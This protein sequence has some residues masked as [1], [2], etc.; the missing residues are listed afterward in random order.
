MKRYKDLCIESVLSTGDKSLSFLYPA[1]LGE[2]IKV[3]GYIATKTDEFVIKELQDLGE[4]KSIKAMLNL[5]DLEGKTF[6]KFETVE[7]TISESIRLALAGTGWT[8]GECN[9]TK[10]RTIR[11]THSSSLAIIQ[12]AKKVYRVEYKFDT[13]NKTINIYDQIGSDKGVYLKD[14]LN[15]VSLD[16]QSNS[17]DFYTRIKA[18]GKTI[19][20]ESDE[21]VQLKVIAENFQYSRKIKE[22]I[23]NDER[24]TDIH[25]LRE[26][27]EAKL[28]ELSKPYVAYAAD[29]IDLSKMNI[30]YKDILNYELGDTI[31]LVS[32]D[33]GIRE[34]QRIVKINEYPDEPTRNKCEI[35][36]TTLNFEDIQKEF[37]DT[38]SIVDNITSDD[39]T[40]SE[41][42]IKNTVKKL[43]VD[44][45]NVNEL[46]AVKATIGEL[47]VNKLGVD[48]ADI[49]FAE[50]D[51]AIINK[52]EIIDLEAATGKID[53]L[54]TK[55][56]NIETLV[57]GNLTSDNIHSFNITADK[58]TMQDGFI[59]NAMIDDLSASKIKS[60]SI[61]TNEVTIASKDGSIQIADN[62]QQFKDKNNK[63]R[64]QMGQ[65]ANGNFNFILLD[66]TGSGTIIDHTGI[67]EKAIADGLIKENMIGNGEI[68]GKK[69]NISSMLTEVN[70]DEN[71]STIKASKIKLDTANQ[72][73]EVGF[74]SM[75]T[76]INSIEVGAVNLLKDSKERILPPLNKGQDQDNYN[77]AR[78]HFKAK[79][80]QTYTISAKVEVTAGVTEMI[81][82]YP[83]PK[84]KQMAVKIEGGRIIYTFKN[85]TPEVDSILLYSGVAGSTRGIG[86][87]FRDIKIEK[88]NKATDYSPSPDNI[89]DQIDTV[90][91]K[92][93]SH[94]TSLGVQA[95]KIET[96]IKDTTIEKSG[97]TV[98]L[99]DEYSKLEQ[100][101]GGLGSTVGSHSSSI[102]TIGEKSDNALIT[103]N[104]AKTDISNL[105]GKVTSVETKQTQ[106]QQ[107]LDGITQRVSSNE[108][109]VTEVSGTVTNVKDKV[110][111]MKVGGRNLLKNSTFNTR[112]SSY[113]NGYT[114]TLN[115]IIDGMNGNRALKVTLTSQ[116]TANTLSQTVYLESNTEY[117]VSVWI[118][119]DDV[120]NTASNFLL[121][122]YGVQHR[123]DGTVCK[124]GGLLSVGIQG[125]K[126]TTPW[127][128][129]TG[130]LRT[131]ADTTRITFYSYNRSYTGSAYYSEIMFQKGNIVSD[132][133]QAPE[134]IT[135]SINKI[136]SELTDFE[137]TVTGSFKDGVI[138]EAEA[139]AIAQNIQ[140]LDM[141]KADIDSE[142]TALRA[143]TLL[144]GTPATNIANAKVDFNSAHDSLKSFI[145]SAIADGK[146]TSS[147]VASVNSAFETYRSKLGVYK[148][149]VQE[150]L[151]FISTT[152]TNNVIIGGRNLIIPSKLET[153]TPY[154][155]II[156]GSDGTITLTKV[157]ATYIALK[158]KGLMPENKEYTISGIA[159]LDGASITKDFFKN[160]KANTYNSGTSSITVNNNGYFSIS[161]KWVGNSDWLFHCF[162]GG[163]VGSKIV[164][165]NLK[166]EVGNKPTDWT[167]SV[168][169]VEKSI[170]DVD[171][172]VT[173]TSNKV[174]EL[175]TNVDS[176]TGRVSATESNVTT[177]TTT[178]NNALSTA[179][180][181]NTNATN[182]NNKADNLA[183]DKVNSFNNFSSTK[184]MKG[185][186]GYRNTD[187]LVDNDVYG[188]VLKCVSTADTQIISPEFIVDPT[189]AYKLGLSILKNF[190]NPTSGSGNRTRIYFGL[191][192]Y[193]QNGVNVGVKVGS[194]ETYNTNVYFYNSSDVMT[195]WRD[196]EA[197]LLPHDTDKTK[198]PVGKNVQTS[199]VRMHPKT[200]RVHIRFLNYYNDGYSSTMYFAHPF[201][202]EVD[203]TSIVELSATKTQ[204]SEAKTEIGK[205]TDRVSTTESNITTINGKV[206]GQETRLNSAETK[207]TDSNFQVQVNSNLNRV[208]K[209]RYIRDY[210]NGSSANGGNHWC[211]LQAIDNKGV[212]VAKNKIVTG[213]GIANASKFTDGII[214]N[215][216]TTAN[217]YIQVDLGAIY[218]NIDLLKVWHYWADGR[219]YNATKTEIS[220][221]GINWIVVFDSSK[222]GTYKETKEGH[223]IRLNSNSINTSIGKFDESGWEISHTDVGTK[224]VASAKGFN[225]LD[226][227]GESIGSLAEDSGLTI[228]TANKVYA[229]NIVSIYE[230]ASA[231]YVNSSY[232]G[233]SDGTSAKPFKN[234]ADCLNSF[235]VG[236]KTHLAYPVT[237]HVISNGLP[238][239]SITIK[240][241][242][243]NLLQINFPVNFKWVGI[244]DI[245]TNACFMIDN[246]TSRIFIWGN[247]SDWNSKNGALLQCNRQRVFRVK[248]S[249]AVV[250][251][252]CNLFSPPS[253]VIEI[254]E[255]STVQLEQVDFGRSWHDVACHENSKVYMTH[256]CGNSEIMCSI[257]SGSTLT[258]GRNNSTDVRPI[259]QVLDHSGQFVNKG[260][261]GGG[262]QGSHFD[263][264]PIPPTTTVTGSWDLTSWSHSGSYWQDTRDIYQ[265]NYG[266]GNHIGYMLPPSSCKSTIA[267]ATIN[268]ASLFIRR[269]NGGG[270]SGAVP[271]YLWGSNQNSLGSGSSAGASR[272]YGHIGSLAWGQSGTFTIPVQ[273]INDYK[274]GIIN[275]LCL[276][277]SDG[278]NYFRSDGQ[279]AKINITYTK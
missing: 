216:Y 270:S 153:Y 244:E 197:Y 218:E 202:Q 275:S 67:K 226:S 189:K 201:V 249:S 54:E 101:V 1:R 110:D 257:E 258:I 82:V 264:L 107:S 97:N 4:Y 94:E 260:T 120:V 50:I 114:S 222:T 162:V 136:S 198:L 116:Y 254:Y 64:L 168:E 61:D 207:L 141:E 99:K 43:T 14:S 25:A 119:T 147:E 84:G 126:G 143:N 219:T 193:D 111:N 26:D 268:S 227:K 93:T 62:T 21:E 72:T 23:W 139:K 277:T 272:N 138:Q 223:I 105:S 81:T 129:Y 235:Y 88:G 155:T 167:P 35:A 33:K 5:E 117:V 102:T 68:G 271:M 79:L 39:G 12:E 92:T 250:I 29:I 76:E 179:N 121:S 246:C 18:F 214:D 199:A 259:G 152:K 225:I 31:T 85:T 74:N 228:L 181:A 65:D 77:Y 229:N 89:Q 24:Y 40:I 58:V 172:K 104:S 265:G 49:K 251:H 185:W 73:L 69:I 95:G 187:I 133:S 123:Q 46:N 262:S 203:T 91:E 166:F 220:S 90:V 38:S 164:I 158:M 22:L 28:N 51:S 177:V 159:T 224:T 242:S 183:F 212:N 48:Q 44:K 154:T 248:N 15:L 80:D 194:D 130:I 190:I 53:V 196:C 63:V 10:R 122:L 174:A 128:K 263:P 148:Q 135:F 83:Y 239:S 182:A 146:A 160:G 269:K 215:E 42:A 241:F 127:T 236:N 47:E 151:D 252:K 144:V 142:Y 59:K 278:S 3:E 186:G 66:E 125:I 100:T 98:K 267:S 115:N 132:W 37:K 255:G 134:D 170:T 96:L 221:D 145:N 32:S 191:Y 150:A 208:Y 41:E 19:K 261:T 30:E 86:V 165:K 240:G 184:N 279:C 55:T 71:S 161:E 169:D 106:F 70:K 200:K 195:K 205:I 75:K 253:T 180:A 231:L 274:S 57:N 56:A 243:G 60:G 266:Y 8:L 2:D 157:H 131:H 52:A 11:K 232:A 276:Y 209:I 247:K 173:T 176:I 9:I 234:M 109:K 16:I 13:V 233:V 124:E 7:V 108:S 206:T 188:T 112:D 36:N 273:A 192:C 137:G 20:N 140:I 103:A 78:L 237:I 113:W 45:I 213:P 256:C 178:A 230:G 156:V 204:V 27:A 211:E 118:R 217:G 6:E 175:V 245:G 210:I 163:G 17:Y 34:K 87:T 171:I 149:R 238:D